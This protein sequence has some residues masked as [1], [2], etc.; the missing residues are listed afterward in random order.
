MALGHRIWRISNT[1]RHGRVTTDHDERGRQRS[2]AIALRNGP[3][4]LPPRRQNPLQSPQRRTDGRF[5]QLQPAGRSARHCSE[6]LAHRP[7]R[8]HV[9]RPA[10]SPQRPVV[11]AGAGETHRGDRPI[12]HRPDRTRRAR[13]HAAIRIPARA[14]PA[15]GRTRLPGH[16][17]YSAGNAGLAHSA[18]VPRATDLGGFPRLDQRPRGAATPAGGGA[19]CAGHRR[20]HSRHDLPLQRA[21]VLLGRRRPAVLRPRR[22][23]GGFEEHRDEAQ[24]R[25]ADRS[26]RLRQ[27]VLGAR[28]PAAAPAPRGGAARGRRRVGQ[29]G[30]PPGAGAVAGPGLRLHPDPL[31]RRPDGPDPPVD[32]SGRGPAPRFPRLPGP[33]SPAPPDRGAAARRPA[34]DRGGSGGGVI[35]RSLGPDHAR[36]HPA[37]PR[38]RRPVHPPAARR[39]RTRQG[40]R[41]ADHPVGFL[42]SSNAQPLRAASVGRAGAPDADSG[43]AALHRAAGGDGGT[44]TRRRTDGSNRRGGR[45]GGNQSS[46]HA[47]RAG[48]HLA[49]PLRQRSDARRLPEGRWRGTGDQPGRQR[50]LRQP[51]H[52]PGPRRRPTAVPAAGPAGCWRSERPYAG[53]RAHRCDRAASHGAF[54]R[55]KPP[56]AADR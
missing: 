14:D 34:A 43:F 3:R 11:A 56:A 42:R 4:P 48:T 28:R 9:L 21:G 47:A 36:G 6:R 2:Y 30:N 52:R 40:V 22:G 25:G 32:E 24:R 1:F 20:R 38:R 44:E 37:L 18:R 17:R 46:P 16:S 12:R 41:G 55:S 33:A 13:Q 23:S 53:P 19:P 29:L 35:L 51:A 39:R 10:R 31:R 5:C 54:R 49:Q 7:A 27:V 15:G 26:L 50:L 8:R 45:G